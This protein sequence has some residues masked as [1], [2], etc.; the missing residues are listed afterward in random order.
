MLCFVFAALVVLLDQ[1]FKRWVIITHI[2]G[3]ETVIIRGVL[4]LLHVENSGAAFS[5]LPEQRWLLAAISFVA[6]L[7]LI[8]ILLRYNEGF[9]GTLGLASVLGGAVGNLIDRVFHG[10]VVDMFRFTFI[11][12]AIFNI[13]DIFITLGMITFC[14]FFI[15]S[16]FKTGG[17]KEESQVS[18]PDEYDNIS[19]EQYDRNN[20]PQE[21]HA[22]EDVDYGKLFYGDSAPDAYPDSDFAPPPE[23]FEPAPPPEYFEPGSKQE[24]YEPAPPSEYFDP[25]PPQLFIPDQNG[26][27]T[28]IQEAHG[29]YESVPEAQGSYGAVQDTHGY[30]EPVHQSPVY[31]EPVQEPPGDATKTLDALSSLGALSALESELNEES[32][33]AD[34]DIDDIL[35]EYG[36]EDDKN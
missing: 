20:Y 21:Q 32:L 7:V 8:A 14:I 29:N 25:P 18:E 28:P 15:V 17:D 22:S 31:Y 33:L 4:N 35:R 11:D 16:S 24:Y 23:Y 6:S 5:I 10:Y 30:S 2:L 12:F 1:L 27:N 26:Y 9:W 3:E 13:A 36:F 34:Y 19:I